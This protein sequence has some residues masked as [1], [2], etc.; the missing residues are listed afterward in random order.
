[1]R[2]IEQRNFH[3]AVSAGP[4][5]IDQVANDQWAKEYAKMSSV[6]VISQQANFSE[7]SCFDCSHC[8]EIKIRTF[9]RR[10]QRLILLVDK[11]TD[12]V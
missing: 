6:P 4:K 12:Y 9:A 1:M 11:I 5:V 2:E 3:S 7:V 8:I 10:S